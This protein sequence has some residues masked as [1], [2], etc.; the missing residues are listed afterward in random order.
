MVSGSYQLEWGPGGFLSSADASLRY[1]ASERLSASLTGLSFQ[2][3]EEYRLGQGRGFGAS[4]V[5]SYEFGERAS[6][7]AG[8][9]L[10][11][12]RDGGNVFTSPWNQGRAW[13]SLR[14][15]LGRDPGLPGGAAR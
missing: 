10:I 15:E 11:R 12:H 3:I 13:T 6:A 9:S 1:D 2:Q 8:A 7:V 4:A 5:A 14:F